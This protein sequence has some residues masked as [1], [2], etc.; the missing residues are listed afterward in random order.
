[1]IAAYRNG[2]PLFRIEKRT[3]CFLTA[4]PTRKVYQ[5]KRRTIAVCAYSTLEENFLPAS[6]NSNCWTNGTISAPIPPPV[7][8]FR[9]NNSSGAPHINAKEETQLASFA[10]WRSFDSDN[11]SREPPGTTAR[12]GQRRDA[13][14]TTA[15]HLI[16]GWGTLKSGGVLRAPLARF[17]S[18]I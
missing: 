18:S 5:R 3:S 13:G 12:G 10:Q 15:Q 7:S 11:Y 1:M 16:I 9:P 6:V 14:G 2:K 8:V 17:T 4:P